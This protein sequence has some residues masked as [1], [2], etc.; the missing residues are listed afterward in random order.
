MTSA[1]T[2]GRDQDFSVSVTVEVGLEASL[3]FKKI[4]EVGLSTSVSTSTTSGHADKAEVTCDG[5]HTC[6]LLMTPKMQEVSGK[7]ITSIGGCSPHTEDE[8]YTVRFPIV[9]GGSPKAT[10]Q[11]CACKNKLGWADEGAPPPCP[12][13]C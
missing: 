4:V 7:K 3:D 11:A 5:H 9:E 8:D 2:I 1:C 12:E 13:D 6:A 10:F